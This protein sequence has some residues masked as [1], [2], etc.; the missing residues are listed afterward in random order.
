M[1]RLLFTG[2]FVGSVLAQSRLIM[3]SKRT[4]VTVENRQ[5]D[6]Q[7]AFTKVNDTDLCKYN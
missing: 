6:T 4:F 5:M 2:A 3:S 1:F 7:N